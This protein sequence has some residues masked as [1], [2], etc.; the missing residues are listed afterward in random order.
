MPVNNIPLAEEDPAGK[1]SSDSKEE[2]D[3]E[4]EIDEDGVADLL[5]DAKENLMSEVEEA[6]NAPEFRNDD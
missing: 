6:L 2:L 1:L 5:D 4:D 3:V